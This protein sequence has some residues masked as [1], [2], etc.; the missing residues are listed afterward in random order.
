MTK[1]NLATYI[2]KKLLEYKKV[3]EITWFD[4]I[5]ITHKQAKGH[6]S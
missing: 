5:T 2:R 3:R 6:Q 4:T 1:Y